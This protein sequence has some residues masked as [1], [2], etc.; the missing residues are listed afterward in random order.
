MILAY[1]YLCYAPQTCRTCLKPQPTPETLSARVSA[2]TLTSSAQMYLQTPLLAGAEQQLRTARLPATDSPFSCTLLPRRDA[3]SCLSSLT[4]QLALRSSRRSFNP[5][6]PYTHAL[7]ATRSRLMITDPIGCSC[8]P[9]ERSLLAVR[10]AFSDTGPVENRST[11][12]SVARGI[13]L[14]SPRPPRDR[15]VPTS[16]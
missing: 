13:L 8:R 16:P 1:V 9:M 15:H 12:R 4:T 2:S 3:S 11:C 10:R 5:E 14:A 6:R 7:R